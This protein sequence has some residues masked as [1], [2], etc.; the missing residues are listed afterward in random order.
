MAQE[1]PH[2]RELFYE[3]VE[4]AKFPD[5]TDMGA[6]GDTL[7]IKAG[8]IAGDWIVHELGVPAMEYEIGAWTDFDAQWRP[9]GVKVA[10]RLCDENLLWLEHIYSKMGNQIKVKPISYEKVEN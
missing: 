2:M 1:Y 10:Q 3:L 8:G 7:Q 5:G 4:E 6:S 9:R